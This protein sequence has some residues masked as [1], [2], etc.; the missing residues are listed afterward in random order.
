M[1]KVKVDSEVCIGCGACVSACPEC[2]ELNEEGKSHVVS[3]SCDCDLHEE[4][5][6]CP[7]QAITVT[8]EE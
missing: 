5:L 4:A 8:D 1:T 3:Q 6:N 7:V 2:F